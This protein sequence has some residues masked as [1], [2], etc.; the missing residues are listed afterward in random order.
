MLIPATRQAPAKGFGLNICTSVYAVRIFKNGINICCCHKNWFIFKSCS[1][2]G[3]LFMSSLSFFLLLPPPACSFMIWIYIQISVKY[4][5]GQYPLL[6]APHKWNNPSKSLALSLIL[7]MA[8][9]CARSETSQQMMAKG[10]FIYSRQKKSKTWSTG[11]VKNKKK[12]GN[13]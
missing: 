4:A 13:G 11:K 2:E 3:F 7:A 6:K 8:I 5:F 10:A 1:F 9:I 12:S